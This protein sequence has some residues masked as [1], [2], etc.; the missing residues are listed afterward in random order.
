LDERDFSWAKE[1]G[2]SSLSS[3]RDHRRRGRAGGRYADLQRTGR[4]ENCHCL[5]VQGHQSSRE[6]HDGECRDVVQPHPLR[7]CCQRMASL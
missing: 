2:E 3:G 4:A 6:E 7:G 1:G 5:S